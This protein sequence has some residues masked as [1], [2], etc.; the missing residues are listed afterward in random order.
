MGASNRRAVLDQSAWPAQLSHIRVQSGAGTNLAMAEFDSAEALGQM[1][2][3]SEWAAVLADFQS[4]VSD[5][6]SWVLSP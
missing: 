6:H 4:H 1:C 5:I 2:D 3:T